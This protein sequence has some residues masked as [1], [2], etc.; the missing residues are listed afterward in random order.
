[1][2]FERNSVIKSTIQYNSALDLA[3]SLINLKKCKQTV[4]LIQL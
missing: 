3:F 1:M 4:I 2:H